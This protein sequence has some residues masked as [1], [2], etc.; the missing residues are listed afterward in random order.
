M[1][2]V[3]EP[4]L[5]S[6]VQDQ[7]RPGWGH[8]GVRRAGAADPVALAAANLLV[9]NPPDA[10]AVEMTLLGGTLE[11]AADTLVGLAGA[12]MGAQVPEESRR[13][14]GGASHRLRAGTTVELGTAETGARAYLALPG[15][16]DVPVVLGSASTDPVAG[17]GGIDGRALAA[18]DRLSPRSPAAQAE[19]RWPDDEPS[20]GVAASGAPLELAVVEGPHFGD[21]PAAALEALVEAVWVVSPRA[22]R[23][24]LRLEGQPLPGPGGADLV[25]LPMVPGAVQVPANGRPIVLLPD[26][27]TVGGYPVPAVV[28]AA[29]LHR[30]GQLRP[31][32]ELRLR[33]V[34]LADAGQALAEQRAWLAGIARR[35]T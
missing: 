30:A 13:L 16:I 21:L 10:P 4:G 33:L 6:T 28:T 12:D 18:G 15:G 23:V 25:S 3:I 7:G 20:S 17:F 19:R 22:D 14:A 32:D 31:G 8:L 27:P 5:Y 9:G 35:L 29:D 34:S 26:A 24:G 1:L 11:V 2:V